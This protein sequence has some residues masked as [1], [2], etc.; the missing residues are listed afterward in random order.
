[1]AHTVITGSPTTI[2]VTTAG[3]YST[4]WEATGPPTTDTDVTTGTA[5]IRIAGTAHT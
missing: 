4:V 2:P 5:P 1:M 3:T